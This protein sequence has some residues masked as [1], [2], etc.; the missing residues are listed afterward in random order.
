MPHCREM[1][2]NNT[3]CPSRLKINLWKAAC[4][5]IFSPKLWKEKKTLW[6]IHN[7]RRHQV[8]KTVHSEVCG[9]SR[10]TG[11]SFLERQIYNNDI[12]KP[13]KAKTAW[14]DTTRGKWEKMFSVIWVNWPFK[15]SWPW[16]CFNN[17]FSCVRCPSSC[18]PNQL[19][20]D[21]SH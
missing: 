4:F 19:L 8:L 11:A 3:D 6:I 5:R 17:S 12:S 7:T 18:K 16:T 20:V 10:G 1:W 21:S 2:K 9:L 14:L 13:D 15:I